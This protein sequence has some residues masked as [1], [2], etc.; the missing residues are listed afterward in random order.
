MFQDV[1]KKLVHSTEALL[2]T[3]KSM[4]RRTSTAALPYYKLVSSIKSLSAFQRELSASLARMKSVL[5]YYDL[6]F[7]FSDVLLLLDKNSQG[8]SDGTWHRQ[9]SSSKLL[10]K[11]VYYIVFLN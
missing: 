11:S 6:K 7:I 1:A 8:S 4:I 3:I 9:Y 2:K 5:Q 10:G